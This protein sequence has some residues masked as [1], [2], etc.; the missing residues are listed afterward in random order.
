MHNALSLLRTLSLALLA[1]CADADGGTPVDPGPEPAAGAVTGIYMGLRVNN[2]TGQQYPD[3]YTFL[4]DGR[5][6]RGTPDEGLD[7]PLDWAAICA[8]S[9]CGTYTVGGS[10]VRFLRQ[11]AGEQRFTVD[12]QGVLRKPGSTQGYRRMQALDGVRLNGTWGWVSGADT[13]MRLSLGADG[14]FSERGT[15]A[16]VAWPGSGARAGGSGTYTLSRGTLTLQYDGGPRVHL[17]MA[18]PPGVAA[19]PVP[20]SVYLRV[21][22]IDRL[23]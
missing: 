17:L 20:E 16:W 1:A 21:T 9:E 5:A 22:T 4:P 15:L 6:F 7:R 3:Y 18:V 12:A 2:A 19:A 8:A 11:D 13:L 14:R 10:E 23:H